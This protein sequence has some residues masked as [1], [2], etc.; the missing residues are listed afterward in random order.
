[1]ADGVDRKLAVVW[2]ALRDGREQ[3]DRLADVAQPLAA[4]GLVEDAVERG[5]ECSGVRCE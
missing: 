4:A 1:M 3:F 2:L 5:C